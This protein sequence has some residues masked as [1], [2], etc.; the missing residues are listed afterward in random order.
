MAKCTVQA[1]ESWLRGP[2]HRELS[3]STYA[4]FHVRMKSIKPPVMQVQNSSG[5]TGYA[6]QPLDSALERL[7]FQGD[8]RPYYRR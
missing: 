8:I 1:F 4:S 2:Y 7:T 5:L 3:R 6:K